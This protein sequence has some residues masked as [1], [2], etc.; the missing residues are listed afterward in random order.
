MEENPY[1][2]KENQRNQSGIARRGSLGYEAF[3]HNYLSNPILF[4]GPK[5]EQ[6]KSLSEQYNVGE[7]TIR[8]WIYDARIQREEMLARQVT[9]NFE[10]SVP[11]DEQKEY[12][13]AR[14]TFKSQKNKIEKELA[15]VD[16][17]K[18]SLES[19]ASQLDGV[20]LADTPVSQINALLK[21]LKE[22]NGER[23]KLLKDYKLVC[24]E[25]EA[26]TDLKLFKLKTDEVVK[27]YAKCV[28]KQLSEQGK[29]MQ[30]DKNAEKK[31]EAFDI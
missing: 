20:D 21:H 16:T 7:Y 11:A 15:S 29:H 18:K 19:I 4:E 9:S 23:S 14:K 25:Y 28:G 31:A 13:K 17:L 3:Y 8:R 30:K 24:D 2:K 10:M 26:R 6:L 12:D 1:R 22:V 27:S 5:T